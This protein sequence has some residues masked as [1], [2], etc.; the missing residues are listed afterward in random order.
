VPAP[1]VLSEPNADAISNPIRAL[2]FVLAPSVPDFPAVPYRD[3]EK[4]IRAAKLAGMNTII[5]QIANSINF[6]SLPT[7]TR[8]GA[9]SKEELRRLVEIA[10]ANEITLIPELKLLTH[11]EKFMQGHFPDLL[12]NAV[13]YDP[14]NSEVYEKIFPLLDELI[15]LIHPPAIHIGHDEVVGWNAR[16]AKKKLKA[17]EKILPSEL[18]LKDVLTIYS[19]L[20]QRNVETWMWGIC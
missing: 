13:T 18:F 17:G 1:I 9:W 20:K 7:F 3:A 5:V 6:D 2:H 4:V 11:Q 16:H 15:E 19:Y 12:Y 14:S 8:Q 10:S